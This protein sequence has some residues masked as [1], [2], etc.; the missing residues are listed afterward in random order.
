M[1]RRRLIATAIGVTLLASTAPAG[2]ALAQTSTVSSGPGLLSRL[3]S[4]IGGLF[5]EAPHGQMRAG[6]GAAALPGRTGTSAP[7]KPKPPGKRVKELTGKRSANGS[8]FELDDGRRQVELSSVPRHYKDAAGTWKDI[9]TRIG[10]VAEDGFTHGNDASGFSS[11]FGDATGKLAKIQLGKRQLTLGVAG[12]SRKIAPKVDGSTVTY[13]GVWDGADVV[14]KVTAEGVKEYLV[15]SKPPAADASFAFTVKTGGVSAKQNTDGSITFTADGADVPTFTIP[16]PFMIDATDDPASPYGKRYSEAVTQTLGGQGAETTITLK[17]DAAW[18]AAPERTWPVVIDPTV[19]IQ[20]QNEFESF[21]TYVNS[22][23]KTTNYDGSWNLPVGKISS[24]GINRAL[25]DFNITNDDVPIGA[26]IDDARLETYFDQALGETGAVTVEAREITSGWE[27]WL[28]NWNTQPTVAA[29]P[30]ATVVRNPGEL[31]RW[32]SF[33][34]TAM[35]NGW[36]SS[37]EAPMN[38]IMLKAADETSTGKI[39]GPVYEA[40]Q[41]VYGGDGIK[42]ESVNMPKLVITYGNPGVTLKPVVTATSTGAKLSWTPYADPTPDDASDDIVE[43]RLHRECPSGCQQLTSGDT[44]VAPLA[45]DVTSYTDTTGGGD[46]N[47]VSDPAYTHE[48]TYWIVV[49]LKNGQEVRSQAQRV[50]LPRP[51]LISTI[52]YGSADTTLASGEAAAGHDTVGGNKWLQVGNTATTLGNTRA[53]VKFADYAT[54]IP[55]DAQVTEAS[56]SLWGVNTTGSGV[57]FNAHKLTRGFDEAATWAKADAATSWTTAGGDFDAAVLGTLTGVSAQ[58]GWRKWAVT[59]AAKAWS[60]TRAPTT[61]CWSR[62]QPRPAPPSSRRSSWPPRPTA[63]PCC[64]PGY[65]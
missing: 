56:L 11:R 7:G 48:A 60:A 25:L 33:D 39:A 43:Y 27:S 32:H 44:L 59:D 36:M 29:A 34:V 58:P 45:P 51:G 63:N 4:G 3:A 41:D 37:V 28:V 52:V 26:T 8:V 65:E 23:A 64:G 19:K 46:P 40:S 5:T 61:A 22:A 54:E 18:L 20:P 10:S 31:S 16:K 24:T 47:D 55:A 13:P 49:K 17:P 38:G 30:A 12:D 1:R 21:D 53:V 9:D 6:T 35:V 62:S 14:Y 57:T 2:P 50:I 42:G 15:L